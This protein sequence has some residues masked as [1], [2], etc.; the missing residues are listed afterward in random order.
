MPALDIL[1]FKNP[2][3]NNHILNTLAMKLCCHLFG[4][5]EFSLRIPNITG[6]LLFAYGVRTLCS[7][8]QNKSLVIPSFLLLAA[9]PFLLD[10][11]SLARGYG[12]TI[13][14]ITA[15]MGFYLSFLKIRETKYYALALLAGELSIL[16]NFPA[17][18]Y[19]V[20]LIVLHYVLMLSELLNSRKSENAPVKPFLETNRVTAVAL[21]I[22]VIVFYEPFRR[23]MKYHFDFGGFSSLWDDTVVSLIV[24]TLYGCNLAWAVTALQIII[25]LTTALIFIYWILAAIRFRGTVISGRKEL[26]FANGTLILVLAISFAHHHLTGTPYLTDRFALFIIPLFWASFILLIDR[27]LVKKWLLFFP[28]AIAAV[29]TFHTLAKLN[30]QSFYLWRYDSNNKQVIERLIG[31]Q[32]LQHQE[33]VRLGIT[34]LFEPSLNYYRLTRGLHWLE[35]LDRD[36]FSEDDDYRYVSEEELQQLTNYTQQLLASYPESESYLFKVTH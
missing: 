1:S 9:N 7:S 16:A 17:L 30:A 11:F 23:M 8:L 3:T 26:F 27:L 15:S 12:L 2:Y 33:R 36:G 18:Y 25:L 19:F 10:F 5:S 6:F 14:L 13:A 34:W 24:H 35:P 29:M 28:G 31:E 32:K 21:I 4:N 22:G 20:S